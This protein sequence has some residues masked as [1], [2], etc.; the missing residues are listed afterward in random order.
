MRPWRSTMLVGGLLLLL[1]ILISGCAASSEGN[2]LV[3]GGSKI[4]RAG[5]TVEGSVAVFGGNLA[6]EEEATVK[7]DVAVFGGNLAIN[8]TITGNIA[9]FG[10]TITR[11]ANAVVRG[12]T[13]TFGG[14]EERSEGSTAGRP[15]PLEEEGERPEEPMLPVGAQAGRATFAGRLADMVGTIVGTIIKTIAFGALGMILAIFL[16][17]HVRRVSRAAGEAPAASMG[18]GCLAIP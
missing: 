16:P 2:Q 3:L 5:E 11:G 15:E 9:N 1:S 7:G 12:D 8:G 18:V 6:I 13:A 17:E 14:S 10:G 4:V